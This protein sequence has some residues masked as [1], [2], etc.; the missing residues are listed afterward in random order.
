MPPTPLTDNLTNVT[1]SEFQRYIMDTQTTMVKSLDQIAENTRKNLAHTILFEYFFAS[2][3]AL[4][5][6]V[7]LINNKFSLL[8]RFRNYRKSKKEP[9]V[10]QASEEPHIKE[11]KDKHASEGAE[12][13]EMKKGKSTK[14]MIN[15]IIIKMGIPPNMRKHMKK[16]QPNKRT[17]TEPCTPSS[18]LARQNMI[19]RQHSG[20]TPL[21]DV[22]LSS[23]EMSTRF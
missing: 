13:T 6:V 9:E 12:Q 15:K 21:P 1:L 14:I 20:L 2:I 8:D 11:D 19:R 5:A 4:A 22:V 10:G 3:I 7:A 23:N 17:S 16:S 18:M